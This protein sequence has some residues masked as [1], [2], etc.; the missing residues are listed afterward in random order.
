MVTRNVNW[1]CARYADSS[2]L[3]VNQMIETSFSLAL[4]FLVVEW[5]A[6]WSASQANIV[7][8]CLEKMWTATWALVL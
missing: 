5:T 2:V 4:Q 8:T 3:L 7:K 1:C 6:A